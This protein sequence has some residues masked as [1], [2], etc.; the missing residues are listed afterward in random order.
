MA[1]YTNPIADTSIEV[2]RIPI[3][4]LLSDLAGNS[5]TLQGGAI[6]VQSQAAS[7]ASATLQNAAAANGNG[8]VFNVLGLSTIALTVTQTGFTGTV[9]FEG[10]ED[11]TNFDPIN[12]VQSGT[13][14]IA[15][16]V[17]GS[18]TTATHVYVLSCSGLQQVRARVS[19]FSAGTV[20]V[21]AHAVP[22]QNEPRVV[23]AN[24]V[25]GSATIGQV[26]GIDGLKTTYSAAINAHAPAATPTDW[27][28]IQGSATKTIRITRITIAARAT[29][30]NQYRMSLIKYSVYL[31]GGTAAAVTIVPHDSANAA[32]TAVVNTWA[33]GLPTPGTAVGKIADDSLPVGVLGTPTFNNEYVLYDFGIRN[34]QAIVLRGTAQY[35]A[36]NS[37]GAALPSGFVADVRIE[38]TEE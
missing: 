17:T 7:S 19:S 30:A 32:A 28:T 26:A 1:S 12:T 15:T 24:V 21:T 13:N 35:L 18:T 25:A 36:I 4:V 33:S 14:T 37:G 31:T 11:G 38:F 8:T 22:S 5:F 2:L 10:S 9:N 16:S 34:S 3:P 29:A 23:N 27:F 6:P 20:T